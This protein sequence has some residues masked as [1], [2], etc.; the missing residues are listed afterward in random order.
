MTLVD[1]R[2]LAIRKQARIRFILNNGMQCEITE[3]G[4]ARVPELKSAPDFN[5]ETEL[6]GAVNFVLEEVPA[7]GS[8]SAKP[9]PV[10]MSRDQISAL[11]HASPAAVAAHDDHEDE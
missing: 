5:L 1:L 9:K 3:V 10:S 2:K 11:A 8:K 6:A 4:V 7:A